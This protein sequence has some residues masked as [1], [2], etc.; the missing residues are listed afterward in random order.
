M[1]IKIAVCTKKT[2]KKYKNQEHEWDYI[3]DRNKNPI[4]TPETAEEYP[5]MSKAQRDNAKDIGGFVGGWLKGGIRRNGCVI[6]RIL[7]TL[8]ADH[9]DD[10]NAFMLSLKTALDGVTYFLYSTHSH[11]PEKPRYRI[12][13]L[14]ERE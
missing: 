10:N 2:N 12:V 1:K 11:T 5:K 6:S 9:I 13:I 14:F 4:R 8:D 3:A 7:G